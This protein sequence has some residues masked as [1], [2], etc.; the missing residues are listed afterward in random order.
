MWNEQFPDDL[1]TFSETRK[2]KEVNK[3]C[4]KYSDWG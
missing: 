1:V 2:G 3:T 4:E